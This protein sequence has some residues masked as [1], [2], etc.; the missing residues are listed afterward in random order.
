MGLPLVL[1]WELFNNEV[2]PDGSQHGFW[3][4]DRKGEKQ[5]VYK[6]H[7]RVYRFAKRYR[8]Q[9]QA[10]HGRQPTRAEYCQ[11]AAAFLKSLTGEAP[12]P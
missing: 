8:E 9:F 7:Q 5:P 3:L 11:A 2:A 10:E 6:S 12:A 1:Y 4:I